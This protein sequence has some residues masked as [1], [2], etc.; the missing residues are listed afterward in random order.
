MVGNIHGAKIEEKEEKEVSEWG[1]SGE[2]LI[3]H[4]N[5]KLMKGCI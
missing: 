3:K 2:Y 4:S 5:G 1:R